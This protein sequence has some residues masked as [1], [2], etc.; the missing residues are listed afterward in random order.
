MPQGDLSGPT[1]GQRRGP[2]AG[3]RD[4]S[5]G[6]TILSFPINV[7]SVPMRSRLRVET[8]AELEAYVAGKLSVAP[9]TALYA[10]SGAD[11]RALTFTHPDALAARGAPPELAPSLY[12]YVDRWGR[13]DDS[14]YEFADG[15]TRIEVEQ[16]TP[17]QV[18]RFR[19]RLLLVRWRAE[20]GS[21]HPEFR[22]RL[23]ALAVMRGQNEDVASHLALESWVPVLFIGVNDGCLGF[24]GNRH[25]VNELTVHGF[26]RELLQG[27]LVPRWWVTDHFRNANPVGA[28]FRPGDYVVSVEEGFPL[29][30]RKLAFLSS[31]FGTRYGTALSLAGATLFEVERVPSFDGGV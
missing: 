15:R 4:V 2:H 30:F 1:R 21:S 28:E 20:P 9:C 6:L 26:P 31:E 10:S 25:C 16:T 27:G 8:F 11:L 19:G 5:G 23:I 13:W 24:G 7:R 3:Q 17:L 22:P 18:G 12:V 29:R 14:A